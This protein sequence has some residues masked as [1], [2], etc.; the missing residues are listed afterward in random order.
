[1]FTFKREVGEKFDWSKSK[2]LITPTKGKVWLEREHKEP[3]D[4]T[5]ISF[6]VLAVV[7]VTLF[8]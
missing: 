2:F 8:I 4:I 6:V 5:V 7:F 3:K 1:M